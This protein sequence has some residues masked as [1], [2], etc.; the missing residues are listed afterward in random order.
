VVVGVIL[1]ERIE[2][3]I[4]I[5]SSITLVSRPENKDVGACDV[6]YNESCNFAQDLPFRYTSICPATPNAGCRGPWFALPL[7]T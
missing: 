5:R 1:S 6:F 2:R 3:R 4:G 7:S